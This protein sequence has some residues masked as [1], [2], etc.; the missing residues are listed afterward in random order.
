MVKKVIIQSAL[1]SDSRLLEQ[2]L[3][4]FF[5]LWLLGGPFFVEE[6]CKDNSRTS[7]TN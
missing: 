6:G 1:N 5:D 2:F 7:E 3:F 4:P